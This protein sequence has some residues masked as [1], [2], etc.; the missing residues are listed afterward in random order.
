[1]HPGERPTLHQLSYVRARP[2]FIGVRD[3]TLGWVGRRGARVDNGPMRTGR[4]VVSAVLAAAL[5]GAA[6]AAGALGD[7]D[8]SFG[9]RGK[10][11]LGGRATDVVVQPD[12][13]VVI[14]RNVIRRDD[15]VVVVT[16][17]RANGDLDTRF[18][19]DGHTRIRVNEHAQHPAGL[20]L[21]PDGRIVVAFKTQFPGPPRP[22]IARLR[23]D[24]K[25]DRL[26]AGDG[27]RL[28]TFDDAW[29]SPS[30]VALAGEG[31]SVV[32]GTGNP[33]KA[34]SDGVHALARY[35]S[36]GQLDE[37]FSGDGIVTNDVTEWDDEIAA[38]AV[39]AHDRVV[40]TG[41]LRSASGYQ[42][43]I[44]RYG[45]DGELDSS[46]AGGGI[47]TSGRHRFG[48]AVALFQNGE[49]AVSGFR[50]R[51]RTHD[52]EVMR[53]GADGAPDAGFGA[54]GTRVVR[55]PRRQDRANA[56]AVDGDALVA[57]GTSQSRSN[58]NGEWAVA[59]I[60]QDGS[61]DPAFSKNGKRRVDFGRGTDS[62]TD[63]AVD[64]R[65]DVVVVGRTGPP[66]GT[67]HVAAVIRLEG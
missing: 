44:G 15:P 34:S 13:K 66:G 43:T 42:M 48:T 35:D 40:V 62:A 2:S 16:R 20:A 22:G 61:L 27:I 54:G 5:L 25:L 31:D 11:M 1:M 41:T 55:F 53:R 58:P 9:H 57:V 8:R 33:T 47:A 39:D 3:P 38:G 46:F 67:K 56:L 50:F 32:V 24:G 6:P 7:L 17:L 12:R 28:T 51:I 37:S 63:V 23:S 26:F 65:G 52:F 10:V 14:L 29:M 64:R 45:T 36:T 60:L 49:I 19:R 21:R 30:D 4:S 18:G 59:R